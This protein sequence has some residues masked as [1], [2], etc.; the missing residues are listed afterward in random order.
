[1]RFVTNSCRAAAVHGLSLTTVHGDCCAIVFFMK[2]SA[3]FGNILYAGYFRYSLCVS[4][5]VYAEIV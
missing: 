2:T 5:A 1:M 3:T 4:D